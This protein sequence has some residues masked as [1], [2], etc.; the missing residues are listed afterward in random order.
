M[1]LYWMKTTAALGLALFALG[2]QG[3][4]LT[5]EQRLGQMLYMDTNLSL[6]RNQSCN[7]C[8]DIQPVT[9]KG[10]KTP[11]PSAGFVDPENVRDGTA[12]SKGSIEVIIVNAVPFHVEPS[13][14]RLF[15]SLRA[16]ATF[17]SK[18]T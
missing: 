11:L 4:A 1:S 9:P 12:V 2:A 10:Q 8:H 3:E 15:A 13:R 5:P 7:S 18:S 14:G 16:S 17:N 6:H